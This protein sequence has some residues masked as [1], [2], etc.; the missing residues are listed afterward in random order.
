VLG[1]VDGLV[2]GFGHHRG[3]RAFRSGDD[4]CSCGFFES[5]RGRGRALVGGGCTL[6]I[7]IFHSAFLDVGVDGLAWGTRG[8]AFDAEGDVVDEFDI[9][10]SLMNAGQFAIEPGGSES[11][12]IY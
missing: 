10:V 4:V 5:G 8:V 7:Y 2:H 6:G 12:Q 3:R 1:L 9:D 11:Q